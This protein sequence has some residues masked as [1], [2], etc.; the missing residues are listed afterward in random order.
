MTLLA[1]GVGFTAPCAN[2]WMLE[3]FANP[4]S[5]QPLQESGFLSL[6]VSIASCDVRE[7]VGMIY[8]ESMPV[9]SSPLQA[10][11]GL[12]DLGTADVC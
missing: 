6:I 4:R 7:G 9:R 8:V 2:F 1:D 12:S 10:W 5:R 3:H 11:W